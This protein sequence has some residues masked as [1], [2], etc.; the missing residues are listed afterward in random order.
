MLVV[1]YNED[2]YQF[3][4]LL[5][6]G[7]FD[8]VHIGHA[9]LLKKAKLQAKINGLDLGVMT[10]AEGK[11]GKM[12]FTL[13]ERMEFLE[14]F[15]VKFVLNIDYTEDFK[16]TAPLE[17]LRIVEEKINIK[18]YMSGKDFRFGAGAKGKPSTLKSYADDEENSVWYMSV[19]EVALGEEKISTTRIKE[20]LEQGDVKLAAEMLGRRYFVKGTVVR[21]EERGRSLLGFPTLNVTYPENKAE[22][23]QGVYKVVCTVDGAEYNGMANYGPRPTFGDDGV[24]LE[25][26]LDGFDGDAYDKTVTVGFSEYMRDIIKFDSVEE[27]KVQLEKDL[28]AIRN[29][30]D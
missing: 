26:Y 19:K 17:F 10:F 2:E 18:G 14:K 16:K 24:T 25:V 29:N 5:V 12:L 3:P 23:K 1:R 7:C 22:V 6:L 15:N 4:S 20:L 8:G 21:G 11:G 28:E 27:L 9:E 30:N 13:D